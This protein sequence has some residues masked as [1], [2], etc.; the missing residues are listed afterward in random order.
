MVGE[1]RARE[2]GLIVTRML[3]QD[4][5][6]HTHTLTHTHTLSLSLSLSLSLPI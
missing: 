3:G 4:F 5:A 1:A 2:R 6:C